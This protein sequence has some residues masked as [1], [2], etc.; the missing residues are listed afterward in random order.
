[1]LANLRLDAA[2]E[3]RALRQ[4]HAMRPV[5]G[6]IDFT[7]C[8][9]QAMSALLSVGK[10]AKARPHGSVSHISRPHCSSENG[11]LAMTTSKVARPP[12]LASVNTGL[13]S[14]SPRS[15]TKSS[16]PCRKRFMR[17]TAPS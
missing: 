3:E 6:A 8:C 15:M 4:H 5:F 1:V 2:T 10:P 7:M 16:M 12:V 14:V 11:G 9:T 13:R 17:A